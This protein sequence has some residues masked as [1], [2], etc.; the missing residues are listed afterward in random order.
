VLQVRHARATEIR[1]QYGIEGAAAA[2]GD[3]VEAAQIYAENNRKL[4][5]RIAR[6]I[7]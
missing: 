2:L 1:E 6:E 3:T 4:A 7:G 5:E